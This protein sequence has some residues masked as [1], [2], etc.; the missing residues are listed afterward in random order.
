M[1][2]K[3][4]LYARVYPVII[5]LLPL[6]LVGVYFSIDY[7]NLYS[8]LG[9]IGLIAFLSFVF[10]QLGRDR[11]KNA[12]K[13]LWEEWGGAP[14]IQILQLRNSILD[15]YTTKRMH[16]K[17]SEVTNTGFA[18]MEQLENSNP[19]EA[20]EI[21]ASWSN[22][23]RKETRDTSKY[24][25]LFQENISYGFRR[26]TWG[27]RTIGL[28]LT[29]LSLLTIC[30]HSYLIKQFCETHN[31]SLWISGG[32]LIIILLFWVVIVNKKWVKQVAFAYA[33]RLVETVF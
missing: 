27:L 28:L 5:T 25:L 10:G 33:E 8:A 23:L 31:L 1:I 32:L 9:S 20:D 11:G 3:Y 22:Y 15:I 29:F 18:D 14:S 30:A 26:N 16:Q 24:K 19:Q 17:L 12:E 6:L 21:Y 4:E 7:Q 13:G 2:N